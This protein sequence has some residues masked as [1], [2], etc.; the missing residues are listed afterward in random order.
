M[1]IA[2]II[3]AAILMAL[4]YRFRRVL[5]QTSTPQKT[6]WILGLFSFLFI[7]L[8]ILGLLESRHVD[9]THLKVEQQDAAT[10]QSMAFNPYDRGSS[11]SVTEIKAHNNN[12]SLSE[13]AGLSE[14]KKELSHLIEYIKDP[15]K[16]KRLGAKPPKGLLLYGPSGTGKT[17]LAR[18]IAGESK[19]NLFAV[20]GS[21]FEESYVGVG[22]ARIRELFALARENKPAF[23]LIDEIDAL[24]PSRST[25]SLSASHTQTIN[26]LLAEMDNVDD[27]LNEG[28][29]VIG[30]TNR[31]DSLDPAL[32][33]PGR[34]DWQIYVPLPNEED[35]R[36]IIEKTLKTIKTDKEMNV[37][38]LVERTIGFSSADIVNVINEA[39]IY[40]AVNN[41]KWVDANAFDAAFKKVS[42][43][44]YE[45]SPILSVK[46]LTA[47][48]IK[49]NFSDIAGM[50]EA[51]KEVTEVV[52]FL[53]DPKAFTRLGAKP[54]KGIIIYGPPGTGKT[55]MAR[56]IAGEAKATFIA[57]SGADFEDKYVGV[58]TQRVKELFKLARKYSPCI[59]FIDELDALASERNAQDN[60][61]HEQ[62]VNAF[63]NEMDN[64]KE[65]QN[66]GIIFLGATNRLDSIDPAVLRPGRF[67]RKVYFRLPTIQERVEILKYYI[68]KIKAAPDLNINTLSQIT[69]GYTGAD[70]ANLVNEAAI[71]ATRKNKPAVDMAA[72]EEAN[73]KI[74]L[75]VSQGAS[76]LSE[77]DRR[78]TAYHEAG[79]ALVG[80]LNPD[81]PRV[82]HKMTIGIRG[83]SLGVT[84][85]RIEAEH[86]SYTKKEFEA[87]VSTSFGGYVAEEMIY[88]K[89]NISAGAAG[90]LQN[91]NKIVRDMV[92]EYAMSDNP[93]FLTLEVFPE[94]ISTVIS[95]SEVILKRQYEV[96]KA[97]LEKNKDKLE[98]LAK[99]LL[100]KETM[101]YQEIITLLQIKPE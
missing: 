54:P 21:S 5:F 63:L 32:L 19:V 3:T 68:D 7:S 88:G 70:L 85:F 80:L 34:M 6:K 60:T 56:A 76:I 1:V 89:D 28:I 58:G 99:T 33:R 23:I 49:T 72:F 65:G 11:L 27:T 12:T 15:E 78:R 61:H 39:A 30:A 48:Q 37:N 29:F 13:L 51:K 17:L 43:Y 91:A 81:H 41:L 87:M 90:D 69:P 96:A 101:D 26:Q 86:Y 22:A 100:E 59:V 16:F 46:I 94:D 35:R 18:A 62:I 8:G 95:G 36:S 47:D 74:V 97:L 83:A 25:E 67:D 92:G 77:A 50:N 10:Q 20:S 64:I 84:H 45:T 42:A 66:E 2:Y 93:N 14:P 55:L 24:A 75:G 52:D 40:A 9:H 4:L 57:V 82:L 44:E 73:D 53:R 98:L 71:E 79:H 38:A 31:F